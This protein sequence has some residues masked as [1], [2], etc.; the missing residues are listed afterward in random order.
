MNSDQQYMKLAIE[1]AKTTVGQT[2]PNPAV[3]S[4][5]VKN[6]EVVGLGVHVKAGDPHAEINAL[7]MAG[8][9]A[10]G[11]TIYVTL[12]PCSH[13]GK[14]P[15][16]AQA[17][18]DAKLKRVVIGS[19]DPNPKVSGRGIKML[20]NAG[21]EVE[22]NVLKAEADQL[23]TI[24]FHYMKTKTPYVFLKTAMS[25]DGKIATSTGESQWITGEAARKDGHKYRHRSDAILVGVQTVIKDNPKLTTRLEG[26][27]ENPIRIVL[28]TQLRT[29]INS[30]LIQNDEAPTWVITGSRISPAQIQAF[31][32]KEHVEIISLSSPAVDI[33]E[34][35][36]YLGEQEI[37]SL[38][39]E[40]G[41]TIADA[42]VRAGK[43]DELITY[44]APKLLGG[45]DALT[46]VEGTGFQQLKD[47]LELE[48]LATE[49][50]GEDIKV[51]AVPKGRS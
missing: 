7:Q 11:G 26:D 16:C 25:L 50:V 33:P 23:N 28:D 1:M 32:A 47:S 5:I 46:P 22:T 35:L 21:I 37:T 43:V 20:E 12:E 17:I 51:T 24:F 2:S 38:L 34:V 36:R 6:N 49:M 41:G 13:Y 40:G 44:I 19:D 14:T 9:K 48:V 31:R 15:P 42:F 27:G 3:G 39:V 30:E 4:V 18:I 8:D 45:K 10:T 29:P